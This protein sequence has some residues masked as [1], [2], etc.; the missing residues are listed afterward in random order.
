MEESSRPVLPSSRDALASEPLSEASGWGCSLHSIFCSWESD[1][2][3][4]CLSGV[5]EQFPVRVCVI[6]TSSGAASPRG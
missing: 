3:N 4:L 5:Q 2:G 1:C 6:P